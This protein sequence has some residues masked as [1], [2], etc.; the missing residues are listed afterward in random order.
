MHL[1]TGLVENLKSSP[2]EL[3]GRSSSAFGLT[4]PEMTVLIGGM[5]VLGA[6]HTNNKSGVF[7]DKKKV[8]CLMIFL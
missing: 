5:R 8:F 4:A 2:E 3:N 1:E 6:N 7:T